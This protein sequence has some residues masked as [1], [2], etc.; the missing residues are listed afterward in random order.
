[1][2][3]AGRTRRASVVLALVIVGLIGVMP[4]LGGTAF[5]GPPMTGERLN[6]LSPCLDGQLD[7][8]YPA[9]TA[10]HVRHGY[11][12]VPGGDYPGLESIVLR[13]LTHFELY[14]DG[15]RASSFLWIYVDK[16]TGQGYKS[17]VTNFP[18]GLPA[19]TYSFHGLWYKD[20]S[21]KG[22]PGPVVLDVDCPMTVTFTL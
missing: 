1:M 14:V 9:N 4:A 11:G 13:P 16:S 8:T 21:P 2:L 15:M 20:T 7:L 19:G 10:F 6:L 5:A 18:N 12:W 17:N 22:P 3:R